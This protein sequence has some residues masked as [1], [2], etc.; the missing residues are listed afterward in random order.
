[1]PKS[2]GRKVKN[3]SRAYV[4][5]KE[6]RKPK[7]SPP[8]YPFL[9]LGLMGLGILIIVLNYMGR[10]PGTGGTFEPLWLWVGLAFIGGGFLAATKYR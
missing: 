4:P 7:S 3:K 6:H 2:K 9:F 8:W 1:V 10:I 5:R